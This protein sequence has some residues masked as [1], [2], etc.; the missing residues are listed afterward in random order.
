[1]SNAIDDHPPDFGH[2]QPPSAFAFADDAFRDLSDWLLGHP[3]IVDEDTARK[4][5]L[6]LD[7]S[8]GVLKDLEEAREKEAKPLWQCWQ[9]ARAKYARPLD[10]LEKLVAELKARMT[11]FAR[12]EEAKRLAIAAE[13]RRKA[14]EI[15]RAARDAEAREREAR[16]NAAQGD[17]EANVGAAIAEADAK[18]DEAK[19]ALHEA[20]IAERD[21]H[22]KIGG[23][24]QR[25]AGLRTT[26]AFVIDD[27]PKAL[28]ALWPNED[29][30][31]AIEKAA[32]AYDKLYKRP[33]DGVRKV[34]ERK[35]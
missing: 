29:I 24:F 17:L 8:N 7:R 12:A 9:D 21:A 25:A 18:F 15:E 5:K 11:V 16:E 31:A 27:A 6:C 28:V 2:N 34:E 22:V 1:V 3:A 13:A 35:L 10:R 26:Y 4:A 23:G 14:A 20:Q 30:R 32:R 33:P 19:R